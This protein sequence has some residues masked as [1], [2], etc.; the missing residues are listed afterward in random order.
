MTTTELD[1]G[2]VEEFAGRMVGLMNDV[3]AGPDDERRPSHR[4]V[5]HA[6]DA[7]AVDQRARSPRRPGSTSATCASGSTRMTVGRIVDYDPS[8]GTYALPPEHAASLTRAAGPGQHGQHGAVHRAD[9][10]GGG[11]DRRAA[12]GTAAACP[13]RASRSSRS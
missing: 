8:A 7:A 4:A 11:R 9:G 10:R 3:D 2:K 5:R 6:G 12:S 1:P 13:T